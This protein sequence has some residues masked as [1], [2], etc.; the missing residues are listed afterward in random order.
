[1]AALKVLMAGGCYEGNFSFDMNHKLFRRT[2]RG[3]FYMT[4]STAPSALELIWNTSVI[5]SIASLHYDSAAALL[6]I[7]SAAQEQQAQLRTSVHRDTS[8]IS[9]R[10]HFTTLTPPNWR[11]EAP[12]SLLK[13]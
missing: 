2:E 3:I 12:L 7:D 6:L 11:A 5:V 1:M 9:W 4:G 8:L 13:V 10:R